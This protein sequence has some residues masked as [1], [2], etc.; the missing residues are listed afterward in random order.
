MAKAT[1]A[2]RPCRRGSL[3]KQVRAAFNCEKEHRVM[4]RPSVVDTTSRCACDTCY[5]ACVGV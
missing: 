3:I 2:R 1:G 5:V 4:K